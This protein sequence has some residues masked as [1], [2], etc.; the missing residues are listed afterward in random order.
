MIHRIHDTSH[1][2]Y[3]V[4]CFIRCLLKDEGLLFFIYVM[5]E[6]DMFQSFEVSIFGAFR[7]CI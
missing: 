3:S 5:N 4:S 6:F 2:P 1:D 7:L